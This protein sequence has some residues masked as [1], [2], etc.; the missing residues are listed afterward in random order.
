MTHH[1]SWLVI[2]GGPR[3]QHSM[4]DLPSITMNGAIQEGFYP[5]AKMG[6]LALEMSR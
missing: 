2:L 4:C 5:A 1:N 3:L 6:S